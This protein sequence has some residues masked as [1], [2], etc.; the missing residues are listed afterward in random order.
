[1]GEVGM[2]GTAEEALAL[3]ARLMAEQESW[4]G[5]GRWD[6]SN[7]RVVTEDEQAAGWLAGNGLDEGEELTDEQVHDVTP[8]DLLSSSNYTT[9]DTRDA[10]LG[11]CKGCERLFKPTRTCRECGCFMAAKT[12]LKDASCPLG[13]WIAYEIGG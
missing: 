8:F 11:V 1:M 2:S 4:V 13:K 10:R 12:W 5:E 3:H 6:A 7:D 9:R